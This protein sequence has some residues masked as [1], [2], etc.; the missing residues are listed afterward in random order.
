[1]KRAPSITETALHMF[2]A[3][4]LAAALVAIT[5]IVVAKVLGPHGKG[6]YSS[7]QVVLAVP[8]AITTG[9]GASITYLMTKKRRAIGELVAPL[10][11]V[12]ALLLCASLAAIVV[13]S[14]LR[15]WTLPTVAMAA[16]LP[17]AIV[18]S[19][20]QSFYVGSGQLYRLN[21]QTVGLSIVTLVSVCGA[22]LV[23]RLGTAGAVVAWVAS[24]YV[25]AA[26]VVV[27][28]LR[29]GGWRKRT[30][31]REHLK[32]IASF[33]GQSAL[34]SSLGT[35]NYRIDS[36]ILAALLGFTSFGIYS[37]A[38]N[39]GELIFTIT[40]P[41]ATAI[42]RHIGILDVKGAA[43]LTARTIRSSTAIVSAIAVTAFVF[44]PW[45]IDLVY[46]SR[47]APAA[48]PLRLLLPGIVA[49]ANAGAF[50]S[51]FMFQV[52]RP[53]IVT[54]VNAVMIVAQLVACLLLV[55]RFGLSGAAFASSL[56]YVLGAVI[57]TACFCRI[58]SYKAADV[59]L[60]KGSDVRAVLD[61][62]ARALRP[63]RPVQTATLVSSRKRLLL[64]GA[65][66]SVA[67]L[68]R[69]E[70]ASRYDV[71]LS[72][73]RVVSGAHSNEEF[74]RADLR[75]LRE[76]RALMRGVDTVVHLGGL[77]KEGSF[78]Q[79]AADNIMGT[80][81]VFEATRLEGVRRIVFASTG[82]VTGFY[83][84]EQPIDETAPPRPD[85]LY[86]TTKLFGENLARLYADK[87]GSEVMCIR[88]GH[89]CV[90]PDTSIDRSIWLSPEDLVQLID[91][92]V[93]T[94]HLHCEI[95]YG[96]S[97]NVERWW[98]LERAQALGYRPRAGCRTYDGPSAQH[99]GI[100][101]EV[102]G[103]AFA[104]KG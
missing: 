103:E 40:R 99:Y 104:A 83:P 19:W 24:N 49:F 76:V 25:F 11:I 42:S 6:V 31:L 2:G 35:L 65:A 90:Q 21:F 62:L 18:L 93:E 15:G 37:I 63:R 27:D 102:Q 68:I 96:V 64:T 82:H 34:N 1:M 8:I 59:W 5:G 38:V 61:P 95:V 53:S 71:R 23:A 60:P 81:N 101:A 46:G 70:L 47:F 33:G 92:A 13:W 51:F 45:L 87:Y 86:A 67:G 85:T 89:V 9:A 77:S 94:P 43:A 26:V 74:V 54:I 29:R 41:I 98:S 14:V 7:V 97:D 17:A 66:G 22:L 50:A 69:A 30:D 3:R 91:I 75:D 84:R 10:S 57:N 78:A 4:I 79:L 80:Y 48:A 16:V 39:A 36:L 20:Q 28:V 52:G 12:F 73:L 32:N 55:P 56:T 100:A 72:D 88:I 58:T 44:G